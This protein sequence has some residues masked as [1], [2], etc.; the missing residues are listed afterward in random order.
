[1]PASCVA[2]HPG[3][4]SV[5]AS[6][7]SWHKS[8]LHSVT[9]MERRA[10]AMIFFTFHHMRQMNCPSQ[11][12]SLVFLLPAEH[13]D[14]YEQTSRYFFTC[15]IVFSRVNGSSIVCI[16]LR[17]LALWEVCQNEAVRRINGKIIYVRMTVT[18]R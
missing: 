14:P 6:L 17:S 18:D 2:S 13:Q 7:L 4:F 5:T 16:P 3:H 8:E 10:Q 11:N 9:V 15:C 12:Y 1:M